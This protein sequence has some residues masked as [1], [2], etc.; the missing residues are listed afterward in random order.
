MY[1]LSKEFIFA[2]AVFILINLH[3]KQ[4][5]NNVYIIIRAYFYT[6]IFDFSFSFYLSYF[7]YNNKYLSII[8]IYNIGGGYFITFAGG[9]YFITFITFAGGGYFITLQEGGIL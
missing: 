3:Y 5:L 2:N 4:I 6:Q 1:I 9:G 8:F 7:I